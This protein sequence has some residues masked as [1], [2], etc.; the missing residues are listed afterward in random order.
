MVTENRQEPLPVCFIC[1][2]E[3]LSEN[4]VDWFGDFEFI[5]QEDGSTL[6]RKDTNDQSLILG[7]LEKIHGLGLSFE[8]VLVAPTFE[9][10]Q[11]K[12]V[13][14]ISW[15]RIKE[16]INQMDPTESYPEQKVVIDTTD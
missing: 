1:L 6:L 3:S 14:E 12:T 5:P 7:T 13:S 11:E 15:D 10:T 16:I 8:L 9:N 4:W 2:K